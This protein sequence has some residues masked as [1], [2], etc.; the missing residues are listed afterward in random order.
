M[1]PIAHLPSPIIRRFAVR[2][3][4]VA[5]HR[6]SMAAAVCLSLTN[7][8]RTG[9]LRPLVFLPFL[10]FALL[11]SVLCPLSSP[12]KPEPWPSSRGA[13]AINPRS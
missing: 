4:A 11:S 1:A 3:L 8:G 6:T 10:S 5:I 13:V 7:C 2:S 12:G 9:S